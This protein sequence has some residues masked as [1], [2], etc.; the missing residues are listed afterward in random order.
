[1]RELRILFRALFAFG[2]S[3]NYRNCNQKKPKIHIYNTI[4]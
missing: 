2:R 4:D 1:M 3:K